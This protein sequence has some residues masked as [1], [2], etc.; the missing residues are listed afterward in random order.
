M[1]AHTIKNTKAWIYINQSQKHLL[2]VA[3][4]LPSEEFWQ[5]FRS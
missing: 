5:S 1:N 3:G 4:V 2:I